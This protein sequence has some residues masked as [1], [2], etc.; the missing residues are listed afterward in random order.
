MT[1]FILTGLLYRTLFQT[2]ETKYRLCDVVSPDALPS[3]YR[4]LLALSTPRFAALAGRASA[5]KSVVGSAC[6]E[7][8]Y[9]I[10][11]SCNAYCWAAR[12][13]LPPSC[14]T[15]TPCR[16]RR[17]AGTGP[18]TMVPNGARATRRTSWSTR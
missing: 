15:S 2:L 8:L 12:L 1:S 17:R 16:V 3:P 7:P 13:L 18:A 6:S 9:I 14:S 10:S 11:T 4:L 5:V